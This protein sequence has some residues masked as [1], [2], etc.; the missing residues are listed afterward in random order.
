MCI[1]CNKHTTSDTT[2]LGRLS[3]ITLHSNKHTWKALASEL[4]VSTSFTIIDAFPDAIK[5]QPTWCKQQSLISHVTPG[6]SATATLASWLPFRVSLRSAVTTGAIS[7]STETTVL[8]AIVSGT[9]AAES[10]KHTPEYKKVPKNNHQFILHTHTHTHALHV[11]NKT[12][13]VLK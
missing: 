4:N 2:H 1:S 5:N 7:G 13:N 11:S 10:D 9:K 3:Y 6:A 8:F 12:E